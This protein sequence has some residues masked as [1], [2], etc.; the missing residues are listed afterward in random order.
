MKTREPLSFLGAGG[1]KGLDW[2]DP[3]EWGW[4]GEGRDFS[5]YMVLARGV[6]ERAANGHDRCSIPCPYYQAEGDRLWVRET[7]AAPHDFDAFPPRAIP[8]GTRITY[9][10][11]AGHRGPRGVGGLI[12]R[13]SIFCMPWMS[14]ITLAVAS[15][16]V[17]RLQNITPADVIAEG[18][19]PERCDPREYATLWDSINGKRAPW[20]SNPWVWRVEFSRIE[21]EPTP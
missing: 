19:P 13:P 20:S 21:Q 14:R 8:V 15:T 5:G 4:F 11:D 17:E 16:R 18:I 12:A 6:N 2:N 1:D 10:A 3:N 9:A 7:W